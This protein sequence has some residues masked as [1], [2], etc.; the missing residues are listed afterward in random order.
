[1]SGFDRFAIH[2]HAD[3]DTDMRNANHLFAKKAALQ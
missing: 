1:M 3:R 2:D